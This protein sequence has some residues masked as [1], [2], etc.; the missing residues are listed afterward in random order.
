MAEPLEV[1]GGFVSVSAGQLHTCAIDTGGSLWCFGFNDSG[2]LGVGSNV[3]A[4]APTQVKAGTLWRSVAAGDLHT[5]GETFD[6]KLYCWGW[7]YFGQLGNGTSSNDT[8]NW[9]PTPVD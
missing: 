2:Q 8:A 1:P 7:N 5:C 4:V 9:I 3:D 6:A